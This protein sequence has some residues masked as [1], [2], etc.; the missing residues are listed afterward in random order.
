GRLKVV[1]CGPDADIER[2]TPLGEMANLDVRAVDLAGGGIS[3]HA[4]LPAYGL[5]L[6]GLKKTPMDIN[7]MPIEL[8]KRPNKTG[9]YV[10]FVLGTLLILLVLAWGGGNILRQRL[11][12]NRLNDEIKRLSIEISDLDRI[13]SRCNELESSIDFLNSLR[14]GR[15][16]VLNVLRDLSERIPDTAWVRNFNFSFDGVQI[17]G[18]AESASELIPL[19]E[20]S[21]LFTDA[22]FQS[23][24][25]KGKDGKERFRI[26][27][28]IN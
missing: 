17:E 16:P 23:T 25:T 12:L 18:H 15:V 11:N 2:L 4:L 7:L 10:M 14:G 5:A 6:N 19:L 3:S 13:Q 28:R 20:G 1:L 22:A 21:P 24:I 27:L 8:R 9:Y 26:G